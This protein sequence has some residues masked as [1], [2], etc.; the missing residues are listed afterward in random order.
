MKEDVEFNHLMKNLNGNKTNK[1]GIL[2]PSFQKKEKIFNL[3][4]NISKTNMRNEEIFFG[5]EIKTLKNP[6]VV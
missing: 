1:F 6:V 4:T 3:S 5:G 2:S